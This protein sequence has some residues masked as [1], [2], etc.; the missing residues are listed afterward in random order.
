MKDTNENN[1][2][3]QDSTESAET[4][5]VFTQAEVN[6]IVA[7]RLARERR[8]VQQS[9]SAPQENEGSNS[10]GNKV[11]SQDDVDRIVA[12]R[13][14]RQKRVLTSDLE[15]ARQ[16]GRAEAE[17]NAQEATTALQEKLAEREAEIARRE[18]QMQAT[19]I[20]AARGLPSELEGFL[21]FSDAEACNVSIDRI[22]GMFRAAVQKG[23]EDRLRASHV[24]LP[25]PNN[26]PDYDSMD[27][28]SFYRAT[29]GRKGNY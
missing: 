2:Q 16:E 6:Q 4:S 26:G 28:E 20:L 27:D 3:T 18:L 13:L 9:G 25:A 24:S 10:E 23:I 15:I 11:F 7:D 21:D 12:D 1:M 29:M 22:E 14:A 8:R 5:R 19:Q 17:K